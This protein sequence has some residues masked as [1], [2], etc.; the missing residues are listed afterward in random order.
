MNNQTNYKPGPQSYE[1]IT[2]PS[3][4]VPDQNLSMR[5]LLD[6]YVR[7]EHVEVFTPVFS[8]DNDLPDGLEHMTELERID[9]SRDVTN[10]IDTHRNKKKPPA[11]VSEPPSL[12]ETDALI[13]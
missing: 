3:L 6:R 10:F 13:M 5:E 1:V 8:D 7:G 11:L 12:R 2:G 4:T 9:M